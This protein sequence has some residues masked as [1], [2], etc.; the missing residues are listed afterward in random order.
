M[1]GLGIRAKD[2]KYRVKIRTKNIDKWF[3]LAVSPES[4]IRVILIIFQGRGIGF[5]GN[6]Y[7]SL[8][9]SEVGSLMISKVL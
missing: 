7:R 3:W 2:Q 6:C 9:V 4:T 8:N 1:L 5:S